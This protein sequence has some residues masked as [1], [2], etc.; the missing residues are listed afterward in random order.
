MSTEPRVAAFFHAHP[1]DE[2]IATSGAM[3]R[4]AAEGLDTGFHIYVGWT[5]PSDSHGIKSQ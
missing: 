5:Q 4:A 2:A 3:A 1:D